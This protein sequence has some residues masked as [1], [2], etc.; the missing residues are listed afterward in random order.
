MTINDAFSSFRQ[1]LSVIWDGL[2]GVQFFDGISFRVLLVG[3][4]VI[5]FSISLIKYFISNTH[6]PTGVDYPSSGVGRHTYVG[7]HTQHPNRNINPRR[8]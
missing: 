8:R 1:L 3:F 4:F 2:F 6:L 5:L 7:K